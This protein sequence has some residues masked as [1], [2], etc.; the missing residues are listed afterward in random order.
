MERHVHPVA[1]VQPHPRITYTL[2][3]SLLLRHVPDLTPRQ[4]RLQEGLPAWRGGEELLFG[5][6]ATEGFD[7]MHGRNKA[8]AGELCRGAISL[9][10][11]TVGVHHFKIADEAGG[12][13]VAGQIGRPMSIH[14]GAIL[15]FGLD[16]EMVDPCEAAFDFA[17]GDEDLLPIFSN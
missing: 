8:L 3:K 7:Q 16:G 1:T 2:A 13:A 4:K 15:G 14:G 6:A 17:E 5:P 11:R 9:E 12:V 10:G